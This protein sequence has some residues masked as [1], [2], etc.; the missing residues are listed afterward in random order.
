MSE[1]ATEPSLTLPRSLVERARHLIAALLVT[2]YHRVA[3]EE[4][5]AKLDERLHDQHQHGEKR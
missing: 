1:K 4:V 3:S 5:I 2:G